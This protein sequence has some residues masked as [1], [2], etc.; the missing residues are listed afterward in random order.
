MKKV[1]FILTAFLTFNLYAQRGGGGRQ[2]S[3]IN[4]GETKSSVKEVKSSDLV[5]IIYYDTEEVIKKTKVKDEDT[6]Y[7]IKKSIQ[8]Y[9]TKVQEISFLNSQT[10]TELNLVLK[11]S[12]QTQDPEA[13]SEIKTKIND[14]IRPIR[15]EVSKSEKELNDS[16]KKIL[17]EKELKKWVKYQ[18]KEKES[19]QPKQSQNN[20]RQAGS[21]SGGGGRGRQ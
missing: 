2:Q 18:K 19:I 1:L 8:N 21:Q 17:S 7:L 5:G 20:Q 11:A 12:F 4:E 6:Q 9:N 14:A 3:Q 16:L 13:R 15:D 10:L